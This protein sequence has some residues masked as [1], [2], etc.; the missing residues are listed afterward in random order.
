MDLENEINVVVES[1]EM[2]KVIKE[3]TQNEEAWVCIKYKTAEKKVLPATTPLSEDN[4][5][6]MKE[7]L[8]EP[9]LRDP[10]KVGHKFT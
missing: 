8:S 3:C 1:I 9:M 2:F 6:V 10:K 7:V 5:K 4:E